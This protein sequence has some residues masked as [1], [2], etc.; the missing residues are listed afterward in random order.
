MNKSYRTIWNEALGAWVAASEL[1]KSRGKSNKS[2]VATAVAAAVL[3]AASQGG[4]A[5]TIAFSGGLP[6]GSS[7]VGPD[8]TTNYTSR[9]ITDGNGSFSTVA[10]CSANGNGNLGVTLYGF[11]T[12][13]TG[14]GGTAMGLGADAAKW[15]TAVGLQATASGQGSSAFG[16]NALASGQNSVALGTT[17]TATTD[18]GI[19]IGG[20]GVGRSSSDMG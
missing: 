13:V 11:Y 10:G 9:A 16:F 12:T 7:G 2:A 8:G 1:A 19:A 20:A 3:V 5:S 14:A 4:Y 17:A 6:C 15:A 18:N